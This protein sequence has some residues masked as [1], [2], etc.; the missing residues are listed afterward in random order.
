MF[1]QEEHFV[2]TQNREKGEVI[3][4]RTELDRE[5]GRVQSRRTG[6][7]VKG[8]TALVKRIRVEEEEGREACSPHFVSVS[9][10][11]T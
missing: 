10:S 7:P 4:G 2:E 9:A 3:T 1:D 11:D 6:E 8:F 5:M